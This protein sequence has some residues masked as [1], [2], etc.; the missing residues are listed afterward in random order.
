MR[1][2]LV[3]AAFGAGCVLLTACA[4]PKAENAPAAAKPTQTADTSRD[5]LVCR[6]VDVTGSR[7]PVRECHTTT[8][9]ARLKTQGT[10][11]L[12]VEAQR[13]SQGASGK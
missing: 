9:W 4:T 5:H 6:T 11:Q 2:T 3:A 1:L 12:G 13:A 10:D 8:E 7:L